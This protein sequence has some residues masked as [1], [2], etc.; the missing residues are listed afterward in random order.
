M[1]LQSHGEVVE[2][3]GV[4]DLAVGHAAREIV[5]SV[6]EGVPDTAELFGAGVAGRFDR[7]SFDDERVEVDHA[8]VVVEELEDGSAGDAC[9][10]GSNGCEDGT[11]RHG[12]GS[13]C[14]RSSCDG[15]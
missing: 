2:A 13:L 7:M 1:R 8:D 4:A 5:D 14:L 3:G 15:S 6:G 10:K 12:D 11:F 9:G